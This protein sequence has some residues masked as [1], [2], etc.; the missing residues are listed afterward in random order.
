VTEHEIRSHRRPSRQVELTRTQKIATLAIVVGVV[1]GVGGTAWALSTGDPADCVGGVPTVDDQGVT[2]LGIDCTFAA[3]MVTVTVP[4]PTVTVPGPTETVTETVTLPGSTRTVTETIT[5][6][7]TRPPTTTPP[8]TTPPPTTPPSSG[9]PNAANTGVPAA[10]V[11]TPWTGSCTISTAQTITGRSFACDVTIGAAVNFVNS[12][13]NGTVTVNSGSLRMT[14]S[15]VHGTPGAT[16]QVTS[17]GSENLTLLRVEVTGGNRGINCDSNCDIRDSWIH[18]QKIKDAWHASAV[19]MSQGLTLIHNTLVCDAPVQPNP[20]GSCSAS[21][22]G[23]GD[24]AAVRDNLIQGN[25]F[26]PTTYAAACAY[27]GSSKG[28]PYS[29]QTANIRFIGNT[30]GQGTT[31]ANRECALYGPIMDYDKSRPGNVW[32]GN[33]WV[34]GAVIPVPAY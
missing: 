26:P 5:V 3:P 20:E 4:G 14:D 29:S 9:W 6:T 34:S 30:F 11:L 22:T 19:R 17:V 10:T 8:A 16:R 12:R 32:S 31:S 23:Y 21:L 25:Y 24:F 15:E 1:L 28:K 27:G 7:P 13:I 18:G 2:H 33:T